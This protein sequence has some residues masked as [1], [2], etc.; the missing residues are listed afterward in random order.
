MLAQA[1]ALRDVSPLQPA[2]ALAMFKLVVYAPESDREKVLAAAFEE[3]AGRIG[4]Y[5]ECSFSMPG[6][7]TFRGLAGT[8][9][10]I[11]QA[12]KRES[13]NEQRVEVLCPASILSATLAAV[14]AAHSYEE[15][16]IEVYPLN[17]EPRDAGVGRVGRLERAEALH[18]FA[19]RVCKALG[20]SSV[21]VVGQRD[22]RIERVA[23]VCGAGDDLI[24]DA[25]RH[26][27]VLITGEARYHSAL[28]AE[29]LGLALIL[30]GH[31]ATERPGVEML[32]AKLAEAFS[33]CDVW[34]SRSERDPVWF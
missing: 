29:S 34:A 1:F 33:D 18:A 26:A 3:G 14:R 19:D 25:A 20:A 12:G 7:G 10:T 11:G 27:D 16:A 24:P 9:P 15:P 31:H 28:Q 2:P 17:G 8:N 30:P 5:V 6:V 32:A 21:G 13:V 23:I 22:R 4:D